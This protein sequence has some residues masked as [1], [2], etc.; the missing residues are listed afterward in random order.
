[1]TD[2]TI[3]R[4]LAA[5]V[6][7]RRGNEFVKTAKGKALLRRGFAKPVPGTDTL[8]IDSVRA[9]LKPNVA[10]KKRRK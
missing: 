5:G 4:L 9:R 6:I 3:E 10:K 8:P 1:M 2:D 7:E